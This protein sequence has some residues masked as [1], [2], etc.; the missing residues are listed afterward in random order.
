MI[1]NKNTKTI[2]GRLEYIS[3][4]DFGI[5]NIE[6]KIDTGAYNGSIHVSFLE[7][8]IKNGI[9]TLC[10]R[11]IDPDHPQYQ[12]KDFFVEHFTQKIVKSS[13]GESDLRYVIPVNFKLGGKQYQSYFS[14]SKRG[15]MR[16]PVLLGR[17]NIKKYFLVDAAKKF[18]LGTN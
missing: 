3:F 15:E 9:P 8:T 4:S 2:I 7:E 5:E 16:R 17:K 10:F 12:D 1:E 18:V 14:L 13:N 6:A 11:L